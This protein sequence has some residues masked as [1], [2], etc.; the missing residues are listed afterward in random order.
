MSEQPTFIPEGLNTQLTKLL[1]SIQLGGRADGIEACLFDIRGRSPI[2]LSG[3]DFNYKIKNKELYLSLAGERESGQEWH[4]QQVVAE[5]SG[6]G[7]FRQNIQLE[8]SLFS[9]AV[10]T[11][12]LSQ[13]HYQALALLLPTED[14]D[15]FEGDVLGASDR[16]LTVKESYGDFSK[17]IGALQSIVQATSVLWRDVINTFDGD[18]ERI[19][20]QK[21]AL[22]EISQSLLEL[23]INYM[24]S[25]KE[26]TLRSNLKQRLD[27]ASLDS[28][29]SV[30]DEFSTLYP[31]K[32]VHDLLHPL[33]NLS[34]I[35]YFVTNNFT[36]NVEQPDVADVYEFTDH[37]VKIIHSPLIGE[38]LNDLRNIEYVR[39][40]K[41]SRELLSGIFT[42]AKLDMSS[43]ALKKGI[44]M[45][46][47]I[48]SI[49]EQPE[50]IIDPYQLYR[51]I[52]NI[53]ANAIRHTP[54]RGNI[55]TTVN[56]INSESGQ[57]A[58]IIVSDTGTGISR[59][60]LP[61]IFA[62]GESGASSSG[63]G[64]ANVK[65]A[66]EKHKGT[67]GVESL[68]REGDK[69]YRIT[70][71]SDGN[72]L[73]RRVARKKQTGTIFHCTFPAVYPET[74]EESDK[75]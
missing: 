42:S 32:I 46:F 10:V 20:Q 75:E 57:L 39:P 18:G 17:Q 48:T 5:K 41:P 13:E 12:S 31:N 70:A 73:S 68:V 35:A 26:N 29:W 7:V 6:R 65:E 74:P 8:G 40:Y 53:L 28:D 58:E 21:E 62:T 25:P 43:Y 63:L 33:G 60:M 61:K 47:D 9:L 50:I 23:P 52:T 30:G 11:F 45:T 38:F 44:N 3:I 27:Q 66:V 59:E 34:P 56:L 67:I 2:T 36:N 1:E 37:I 19:K 54:E 55:V 49:L 64:L 72:I 4:M 24:T 16:P 14:T 51:A 15:Y 69:I 71:D 22:Y